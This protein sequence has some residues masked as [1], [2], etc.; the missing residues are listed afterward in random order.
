MW[1]LYS[2]G[3]VWRDEIESHLG[4]D[5][6]G[7]HLFW[8]R[9]GQGL[10]ET[11][12]GQF[13]LAPG[14]Q[15]WIVDLRQQR[16]YRPIEGDRL[17]T[18]SFRFGGPLQDA[19]LSMLGGAGEVVMKP[20][21]MSQLNQ[22]H[23]RLIRNQSVS[24][25]SDEWRIHLLIT[26]VWGN[27]LKARGHFS[28]S[29]HRPPAA[30]QQVI[31]AVLAKPMHDWQASELSSVAGISYSGL[32]AAFKHS[33]DE[34]LHDFLQ[35]VR[36]DQAHILLADAKLSIKEVSARLNFNDA[37]YFSHWFQ[38]LHGNTPGDY[39]RSIRG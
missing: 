35:Q 1:H 18:D 4:A 2:V 32:R 5:K 34:T 15:C 26:Q 30:V 17:V 27:L 38:R 37:T 29:I 39:R 10:L 11:P 28:Q 19:W 36:L 25:S 14:P 13:S 8:I 23:R 16:T 6:A 24:T 21:M 20:K 3:T 22:V 12:S 9:R 31:D 33:R 7:L